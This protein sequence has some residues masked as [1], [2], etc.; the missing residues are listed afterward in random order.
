LVERVRLAVRA[1]FP[2]FDEE[3][4]RKRPTFTT[5]PPRKAEFTQTRFA[6]G[7]SLLIVQQAAASQGCDAKT[8]TQVAGFASRVELCSALGE[9]EKGRDGIFQ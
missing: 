5:D 6:S 8:A 7:C 4:V 9:I 3:A 1:K 2:H